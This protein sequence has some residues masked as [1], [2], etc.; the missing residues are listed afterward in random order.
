M[1]NIPILDH[2]ILANTW[3]MCFKLIQNVRLEE[4]WVATN[5]NTGILAIDQSYA[6]KRSIR[7]PLIK[8]TPTTHIQTC[9]SF[10]WRK[11]RFV[12]NGVNLKIILLRICC[13]S[14]SL[15]YVIFHVNL[16]MKKAWNC[17]SIV[18]IH[19]VCS[20]LFK[21][22]IYHSVG[23]KWDFEMKNSY[24]SNDTWHLTLFEDRK[25]V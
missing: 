22:K 14:A 17:N 5:E 24:Y 15:K 9:T 23:A 25:G 18:C 7:P 3:F 1:K 12:L 13:P 20:K 11:I 8:C 21:L 19:F 16:C 2:H 6:C 4:F 10:K